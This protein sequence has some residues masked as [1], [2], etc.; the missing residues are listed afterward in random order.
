MSVQRSGP[1][2]HGRSGRVLTDAAVGS[3]GS[4]TQR[5]G[6]DGH[7]GRVP[8]DAVVGYG[9]G[10][11]GRVLTDA[12]VGSPGSRTQHLGPDG[13]SGRVLMDAAV[14]SPGSRTQWSCPHGHGRGGRV[15]RVTGTEAGAATQ[16]SQP[17]CPD[18]TAACRRDSSVT[19]FTVVHNYQNW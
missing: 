17:S 4:R 14:G 13:H 12:A 11:S 15:P 16:S 9:H 18:N 2:G 10:R 7:S 19:Y 1:P 8:M 3:P 6:P 5:S